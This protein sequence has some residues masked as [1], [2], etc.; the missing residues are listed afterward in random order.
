MS[1]IYKNKISTNKLVE[2][3]D[4]RI[5]DIIDD[6][7]DEKLV[8]PSLQRK[9]VWKD[10]Q[11]TDLFDS[12]MQSYPIGTFMFWKYH[13]EM[14]VTTVCS[15]NYSLNH[16]VLWKENDKF[17]LRSGDRVSTL[18][19]AMIK[20]QELTIG[21]INR[22]TDFHS[23][24]EEESVLKYKKTSDNDTNNKMNDPQEEKVS[25][26]LFLNHLFLNILNA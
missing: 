19:E 15:D 25:D 21:L 8:L 24:F 9:F 1:R 6:I 26:F 23:P 22:G 12:I 20:M 4:S 13:G 11:I 10:S 5:I 18:F 7:H 2:Y 17:V 16:I 3:K 14:V